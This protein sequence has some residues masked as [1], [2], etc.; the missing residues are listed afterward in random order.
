MVLA[1]QKF[2]VHELADEPKIITKHIRHILGKIKHIKKLSC[3]W[4]PRM[5]TPDQNY[6]REPTSKKCLAMLLR[7][8]TDFWRR[9]VTV[10]H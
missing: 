2:K 5:L 9:L 4:V 10:I 6:E 8:R 1:D 3:R 7:N